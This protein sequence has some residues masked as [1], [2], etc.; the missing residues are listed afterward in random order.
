MVAGKEK[1]TGK[2][3]SAPWAHSGSPLLLQRS[4]KG[5]EGAPDRRSPRGGFRKAEPR[6]LVAGFLSRARGAQGHEVAL[7]CAHTGPTMKSACEGGV[8]LHSR[9]TENPFAEISSGEHFVTYD[10]TKCTILT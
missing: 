10:L 5:V 6:V 7:T 9:S 4:L 2:L 3:V 1:P 8:Q